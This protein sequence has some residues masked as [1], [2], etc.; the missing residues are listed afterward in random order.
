MPF[1]NCISTTSTIAAKSSDVD[2]DDG[3]NTGF[4]SWCMCACHI[5]LVLM[6][7]AWKCMKYLLEQNRSSFSFRFFCFC[8]FCCSTGEHA[9]HVHTLDCCK[10]VK[11][12][13][14]IPKIR[15]NKQLCKKFHWKIQVRIVL[16]LHCCHCGYLHSLPWKKGIQLLRWNVVISSFVH[17]NEYLRNIN[18]KCKSQI[19]RQ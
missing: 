15:K 7:N 8:L 12:K 6:N 13:R 16:K 9:V 1:E 2:D 10:N 19:S 4:V 11:A 18:C 14:K 3:N 17:I 5:N